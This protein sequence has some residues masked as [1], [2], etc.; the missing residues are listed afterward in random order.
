MLSKYKQNQ[1]I[2]QKIIP[3]INFTNNKKLKL[4]NKNNI[5]LNQL[6]NTKKF[7]SIYYKSYQQ[8]N[9]TI[10][11]IHKQ[12]KNPK[13][14]IKNFKTKLHILNFKHPNIIKTLTTTPFKKFKKK[15]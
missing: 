5:K 11:I 6:L 12:N 14:Q 13:T 3:K 2:I 1:K 10:K 15:T 8:H 9:I 7:K 4:I